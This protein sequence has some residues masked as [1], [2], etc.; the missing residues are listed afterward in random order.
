MPPKFIFFGTPQFAVHVLEALKAADLLPAAIVT[1]PDKPRGRGLEVTPPEV[2]VWGEEH[3][4]D[5]LQPEKL[6]DEVFLGE[7]RNT[8]WD[9]FVVAAYG[10]LLPK[11]LLDIPHKG[12]L[13]VHPSLLPRFRG[14][15]PIQSQIL[16]DERKTGVTIMLIDEE[17]DHG[18]IVAQAS[19]EP[20]PWPLSYLML[21]ELLATEG[22]RLL[23]EVIPEWQKGMLTP[24]P[25]RHEDATYTK[26]ITKEDGRIDPIGDAYTNYLKFCAYNPWP[27]VFFFDGDTRVKITDAQF[28]DNTF[29]ILK[30][31]PEGKREMLYTDYLRQHTS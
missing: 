20:D 11:E 14:A 10:K 3:A 23:A 27:G 19:I 17:M 12:T 25:Q 8:D 1:A 22:G 13:N 7:L 31:T 21:E 15:S 2:K 4:I 18:P 5:V 9:F 24:E 28:E 30:V 26:K 29:K 6:K 16:A